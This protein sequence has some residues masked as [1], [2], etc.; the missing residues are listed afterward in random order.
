LTAKLV[1]VKKTLSKEK[2]ARS[3]VDRSLAEKKAAHQTVE[4]SLQSSDEARANLARDIE[5]VQTSLTATASKLSSKSSALDTKV[6]RVH[7]MELKLKKAKEK[8]KAAKEKLKTA[9]DKMM[10]QGQLLDSAQQACF[11]REFSSS[12]VISL[13]V[14]NAMGPVKNHIPDFDAEILCKDFTV[15]D[16]EWTALDDNIYDTAHHFVS[17]YDFSALAESDDNNSPSAL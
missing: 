12:T 16:V 6:I 11:K 14:A 1:A 13:I 3:T 4:Q 7:E 10:S 17:L 5:S 15:D 9:E 2:A 8:L